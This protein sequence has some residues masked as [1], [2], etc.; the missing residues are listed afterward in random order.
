V[1]AATGTR[2]A[3]LGTVVTFTHTGEILLQR[4][5]GLAVWTRPSEAAKLVPHTESFSGTGLN[6]GGGGR[7]VVFGDPVYGVGLLR[8]SDGEILYR[9]AWGPPFFQTKA[10]VFDGPAEVLSTWRIR[11]GSDVLASPMEDVVEGKTM[12]R[13]PNLLRDFLDGKSIA[14]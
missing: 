8:V 13:H 1:D 7:Y 2:R 11:R 5:D 3:D 10:G 4:A 9:T 14:P 12:F 6:I